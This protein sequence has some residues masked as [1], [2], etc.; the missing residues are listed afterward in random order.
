MKSV[1]SILGFCLF[2]GFVSIVVSCAN[3]PGQG[4]GSSSSSGG[5]TIIT[6]TIVTTENTTISSLKLKTSLNIDD[7]SGLSIVDLKLKSYNSFT[8][9]GLWYSFTRST[10]ENRRL[11]KL[12]ADGTLEEVVRV[13]VEVGTNVINTYSNEVIISIDSINQV[14]KTNYITNRYLIASVTNWGTNIITNAVLNPV[15]IFN[16]SSNF[17]IIEMAPDEAYYTNFSS[18][19]EG[20]LV[21]K[22]TGAVYSMKGVGL[23][24]SNEY[25]FYDTIYNDEAGNIYYL[26]YNTNNNLE[27]IKIDV[28]N[29]DSVVKSR[30]NLANDVISPMTKF[31]VD[32]D[33]NVL[34]RIAGGNTNRF[35]LAGGGFRNLDW[36]Y[37]FWISPDGYFHSYIPLDISN[38]QIR[39]FYFDNTINDVTN[40]VAKEFQC[41][42]GFGLRDASRTIKVKISGRPIFFQNLYLGVMAYDIYNTQ[43]SIVNLSN[44]IDSMEFV[45]SID[46]FI[47]LVGKKGSSIKVLKM[48]DLEHIDTITEVDASQYD[49]YNMICIPASGGV[50]IIVHAYEYST[51]NSVIAKVDETGI[52]VLEETSYENVV[53]L[54]RIR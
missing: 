30:K 24:E 50:N 36:V 28:S 53:V 31:V 14:V 49:I 13:T 46:N 21:N 26:A 54:E 41:S 4:E 2:V 23:P 18:E 42:D 33:G 8:G 44:Y 9:K 6:N 34:Y 48:A 51:G 20:F 1:L 35:I 52:H 27:I 10:N 17:V 11:V 3:Q 15:S 19:T 5:E 37:D 7:A 45:D 47:Y 40:T 22:N 12:K 32:K 29:P 25:K 39:K 16:A 38:V 43:I